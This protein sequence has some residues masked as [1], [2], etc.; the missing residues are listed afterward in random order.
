MVFFSLQKKPAL[1][2]PWMLYTIVSLISNTILQVLPAVEHSPNN[3]TAYVVENIA[4]AVVYI[5]K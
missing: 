5:C 4:I 3:D 2:V 1:L